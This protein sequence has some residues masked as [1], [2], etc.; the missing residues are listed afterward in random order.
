MIDKSMLINDLEKLESEYQRQYLARK[1][2]TYAGACSA[3]QEAI[4]L[5]KAQTEKFEWI[6]ADAEAP[7]GKGYILLSFANFSVP[8]VGRYEEDEDGGGTY[9]IGDESESCISQEMIVNAWMYLPTQY[10]EE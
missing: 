6:N 2:S 8:L 3:I 9:Y 5:V 7:V 4:G 1:T 10:R